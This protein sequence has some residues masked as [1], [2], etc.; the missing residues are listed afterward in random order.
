MKALK[1]NGNGILLCLLEIAVGILLLINYEKLTEFIIIGAGVILLAIGIV[2]ALK[3]FRTE[4]EEARLGQLLTK[5][6][7]EIAIGA[8]LLIKTDLFKS[9]LNLLVVVYGIVIL[10]AGLNK[11]QITA[12][13]IRRKNDKWFMYGISALVTIVC[14]V[15]IIAL[16]ET[17]WIWMFI[18]IYLIAQ[19]V[20]DVAAL[21]VS[22][23]KKKEVT[24]SEDESSDEDND[25]KD[26]NDK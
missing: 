24:K 5:G 6:L 20:L 9:H 21:I 3:Y 23:L 22:N 12:D 11:V 13:L 17:G 8:F 4:A 1:Q 15:I 16:A 10:V 2:T 26:D 25:D 18:G 19:A 7:T 14:A